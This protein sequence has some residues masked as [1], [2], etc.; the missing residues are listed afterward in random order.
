A[1][2]YFAIKKSYAR[3]A[4]DKLLSE[5]G[6]LD[7]TE[8]SSDE[9]K[10]EKEERS[11]LNKLRMETV[12]Q[13]VLESGASSVIDLGCGECRLTAMLLNESQIKKVT[14]CDVAVSELEKAA[15]RLNLDRMATYKKNKLTLMQASLTYRDKRF[16]GYDCACAIEVIEHIEPTRISAFERSIFE[17]ACPRTVIITTPNKEYNVNYEK[18]NENDL[19]HGDH[20]FEWTREQF[21]Q[22]T[23]SVCDKFGY[24]CKISEI[25]E[26]DGQ[27]GAPTQMGVFTKNG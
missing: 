17:F 27:V 14:A 19:R 11:P 1:Q 20:R 6:N 7:E 24:S 12:K 9:S 16:E 15:K 25:G 4:L 13:A 22:W 2:R 21:K 23:Q 10:E 26:I 3:R 18:M 8:Q 5:E